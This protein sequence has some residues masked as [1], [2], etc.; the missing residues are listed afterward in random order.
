MRIISF[1]KLGVVS[2]LATACVDQT[3]D[4]KAIQGMNTDISF[5]GEHFSVPIGSF[6]PILLGR[7][8]QA[9]DLLQVV[10]GRY[11][12]SYQNNQTTTVP[13]VAPIDFTADAPPIAGIPVDLA[14][15]SI[16]DI[17]K[18]D[19]AF[20]YNTLPAYVPANSGSVDQAVPLTPQQ[21][22]IHVI[23]EYTDEIKQVNWI[24]F[25]ED[26][27]DKGQ[28]ITIAITPS[29]GSAI[30][31]GV[32][33]INNFSITF[34]YGFTLSKRSSDAQGV[35]SNGAKTYSINGPIAASSVS[36]YVD[37]ITFNPLVDQLVKGVLDYNQNVTYQGSF[38][39]KGTA[40]AT[41]GNV[42]INVRTNQKLTFWDGSFDTNVVTADVPTQNTAVGVD[43]ELD[44]ASIQDIRKVTLKNPTPIT[45]QVATSGLP[46]RVPSL[47]LKNYTIAFPSYMVFQDPTI[48]ATKKLTIN[49]SVPNGA[50][51]TKQ[52]FLTGFEFATNPVQNGHMVVSA[53]IT[54]SGAISLPAITNLHSTE[55]NN[56]VIKPSVTLGAMQAGVIEAVIKPNVSIAPIEIKVDLASSMDFLRQSVLD[57]DRIALQVRVQNPTGIVAKLGVR[58][59]PYDENNNPIAANVVEQTTG[60]VFQPGGVSSLWLSNTATGM[61]EGYTLVKNEGLPRLFRTLPSRVEATL[62][63]LADE[64]SSVID[65]NANQASQLALDYALVAPITLGKD[66]KLVYKERIKGL[67]GQLGDALKYTRALELTV[68]AQ[69]SIPLDLQISAVGLDASGSPIPV[70]LAVEGTVGAGTKQGGYKSSTVVL[71]VS[72]KEAGALNRLDQIDLFF[73][74]STA[75]N[76]TGA[77]L[78]ESQALKITMS[79]R[80]PGGINVKQNK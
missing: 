11:E 70:T 37:K 29:Y 13:T 6:E 43:K 60:M 46:A 59:V 75:A 51:Y 15:V 5:G 20:N 63:V 44:D 76:D 18:V 72:E 53:D 65:L 71:S 68:E 23:Y 31:G 56:I 77:S 1:V 36:F 55:I 16:N 48:N 24:S 78:Q 22:P 28:L 73:T 30:S 40:T 62:S 8:I 67:Q 27:P 7:F 64:Q 12:F 54:S 58:L 2:C 35:I 19:V 21:A 4:M 26:A 32:T 41:G 80:I 42:G 38:Q 25:G 49:A 52:V 61:P 14:G 74:G 9:G 10:E 69:N 47:D 33:E 66:F 79:A 45:I 39:I 57:L 50:T 34:P 3:Y 17:D